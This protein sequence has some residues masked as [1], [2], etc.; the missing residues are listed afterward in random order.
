MTT[1]AFDV[2]ADP[3]LERRRRIQSVAS[4][5]LKRRKIYSRIAIGICWAFLAIAIVPLIAVVAYVVIKGLPAWNAD[6]FT[7]VTEPEGIPG[8]GVWNAIVGT[9]V[10]GFSAT[11][12]TVPVGLLCGLFLAESDGR[13]AAAIRFAADVMTGVPSITIGIFGYIAIVKN[14]GYSG[15]AGAFAIG[16]IMLPVIIRAGETAIRGVPQH[17]SE[18]ALALGAR[19][20]TIARR[21]VVPAALPGIITGVLLA[22]ARGLGETA[23][24]LLTIFGNQFMQWN[25][26]KPMNALPLT[27][28]NNSSQPYPDLVQI[29]WG[30][31]LLLLVIV[32][33][34]SVGSRVLAAVL[35]KE[36][37]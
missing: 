6:F 17:L 9:A 8:G 26:T 25:P 19:R 24:L 31:A 13:I 34:L 20:S 4:A 11:L 32:L 33:V 30:A 14:F 10:I 7:K 23:P 15:L 27:I 28:F 12:V 29:A 18:A 2:S 22:V 21:V 35:Q 36:R 37:R 16:I 1:L 5:S 3:I